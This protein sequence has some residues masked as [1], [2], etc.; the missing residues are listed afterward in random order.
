MNLL[1]RPHFFIGLALLML[2]GCVSAPQPRAFTIN[3]T[4]SPA[5]HGTSVQVDMVGANTLA[6][7]PKWQSYS[8]TEYWQ[9]GNPFRRDAQKHTVQFSRDLPDT[10]MLLM[11]DSLWSSWLS[12][13]AQHLVIVADLPGAV[14]DQVGNADPRRLILPLDRAA[15]D[16]GV[17]TINILV[18]ESGLKLLTP[19][20]P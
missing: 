2:G 7:L 14:T 16:S 12:T 5:L 17:T 1:K 18:Q 9:P 15:W 6:D 8:V 11:G 10:Q 3:L 20:K 4:L 13:G 19:R